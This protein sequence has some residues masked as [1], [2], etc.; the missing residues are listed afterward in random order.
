MLSHFDADRVRLSILLLCHLE[1]VDVELDMPG[2]ETARRSRGVFLRAR[3]E[4]AYILL[5]SPLGRNE[6]R[7][8][9]LSARE[10]GKGRRT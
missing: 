8:S 10:A 1:L 9:S 6:P 3:L 7:S 2:R 4:V 5:P